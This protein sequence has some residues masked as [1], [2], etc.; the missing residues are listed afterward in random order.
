MLVFHIVLLVLSVS[1]LKRI[2]VGAI[3]GITASV[4]GVIPLIGM[5][6]HWAAAIALAIDALLTPRE[7]VHMTKEDDRF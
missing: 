6:L 1:R 2:S 7:Q 3:V 5:V 4:L